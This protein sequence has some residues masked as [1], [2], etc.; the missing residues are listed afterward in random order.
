MVASWTIAPRIELEDILPFLSPGSILGVYD[1]GGRVDWDAELSTPV[2]M[3]SGFDL[4]RR[5]TGDPACF[6]CVVPGSSSTITPAELRGALSVLLGSSR[7][8]AL[9]T[10]RIGVLLGVAHRILCPARERFSGPYRSRTSGAHGQRSSGS[11]E[12]PSPRPWRLIEPAEVARH[13]TM[14]LKVASGPAAAKLLEA[15][16]SLRVG[17]EAIHLL[18]AGGT[19]EE[20]LERLR[21]GGI[22]VTGSAVWYPTLQC[23]PFDNPT[24]DVERLPRLG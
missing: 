20:I 5:P 9:G 2:V 17:T 3:L 15:W 19:P 18:L 14:S 4:L 11:W 16:P 10:A 6:H 7:G 12:A 13:A 24:P 21:S 23:S 1:E 8:L 22:R